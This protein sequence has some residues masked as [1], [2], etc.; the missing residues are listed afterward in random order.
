M[1]S[2]SALCMLD[3]RW[4][5]SKS[6]GRA[7]SGGNFLV[8]KRSP[9][10]LASQAGARCAGAQPRPRELPRRMRCTRRSSST[11]SSRPP[12]AACGPSPRSSTSRRL[13]SSSPAIASARCASAPGR[14][15]TV[16]SKRWPRNSSPT[17]S[18]SAQPP[19][20]VPSRTLASHTGRRSGSP[21]A[22]TL[23]EPSST[24][25]PAI[26][27]GGPLERVTPAWNQHIAPALSPARTV[28]F[29]HAC[30]SSSSTPCACHS[31]SRLRMEPPPTYT[32]SC[33]STMSASERVVLRRL[34]S[35]TY[36]GTHARS[37]K[38][39][40]KALISDVVSPDA[41]GMNRMR[42][43]PTSASDST[44]S[45]SSG[46]L[47]SIV[48]PPPP[49]A[50]ICRVSIG[51][52]ARALTEPPV[53]CRYR[54]RRERSARTTEER[55]LQARLAH[56]LAVVLDQERVAVRARADDPLELRASEVQRHAVLCGESRAH[57]VGHK[58]VVLGA[59][60]RLGVIVHAV[61]VRQQAQP[62]HDPRWAMEGAECLLE[63][64]QRAGRWSAQDDAPPPCFAQ[65]GVQPMRSPRAEHAEHVAATHV[66]QILAEQV[67]GEVV[68]HAVRALIASEQR[69][70]ASVA[71]GGEAPIEAHHV[72][73]GVA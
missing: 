14:E 39:A 52:A 26:G 33:S 58:A 57:A 23:S 22:C 59:S 53:S 45:S 9:I 62:A 41:V 29:C 65:D 49:I 60:L 13:R 56:A 66:D 61:G 36:S 11:A 7:S 2:C 21:S 30:T 19:G 42:G 8:S 44:K 54:R 4:W 34:N 17:P 6:A 68:L 28:P 73:V 38:R 70:V 47:G 25:S 5:E 46:L 32:M 71:A 16:R 3:L 51:T 35:D 50:K 27:S 63:P 10:P 69:Q 55:C 1:V 20:S 72:V 18:S 37:P 31:A 12:S 15:L 64:A 43:S 24:P 48:K 67:R 40:L